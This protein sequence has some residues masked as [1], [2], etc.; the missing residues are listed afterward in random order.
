MWT[1]SNPKALPPAVAD[2]YAAE[3]FEGRRQVDHA[4]L[5]GEWIGL[6]YEGE[7]R[8]IDGRN[9]YRLWYDCGVRAAWCVEIKK[10]K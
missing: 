10:S 3:V 9:T 6:R 8:L 7:F 2:R 4:T 1:W 5:N